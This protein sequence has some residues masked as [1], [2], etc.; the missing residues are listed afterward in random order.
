MDLIDRVFIF[1]LH[2]TVYDEVLEFGSAFHAAIEVFLEASKNQEIQ[3][4]EDKFYDQIST[5]HN[6]FETDWEHDIWQHI[7][8]IKN[9]DGYDD[10][11]EQAK[12]V[13]LNVSERL[14]KTHK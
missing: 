8:E 2:N 11:I 9:L 10:L 3:I 5:C 1:D 6:E 12:Q 4:N 13:R 14:T 7:D